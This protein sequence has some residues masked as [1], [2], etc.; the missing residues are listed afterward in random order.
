MERIE[1]GTSI[2]THTTTVPFITIPSM[3]VN[4]YLWMRVYIDL[5]LRARNDVGNEILIEMMRRR[6]RELEEG[7]DE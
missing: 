7:S 4:D 5:Y 6:C 1:C 3:G 2:L